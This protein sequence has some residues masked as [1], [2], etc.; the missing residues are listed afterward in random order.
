MHSS[1]LAV[2]LLIRIPLPSSFALVD[3]QTLEPATCLLG[4]FSH[5]SPFAPSAP[6][7][8]IS[9]FPRSLTLMSPAHVHAVPAS[10]VIRVTDC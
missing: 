7:H 9:A 3:A 6:A 10:P 4:R 8:C 2:H 5:D 1:G